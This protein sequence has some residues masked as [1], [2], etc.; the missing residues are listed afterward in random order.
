MLFSPG[1]CLICLCPF[2]PLYLLFGRN[3]GGKL[4]TE[5]LPPGMEGPP[6][7]PTGE[8]AA[9]VVLTTHWQLA[10][11]CLLGSWSRYAS[12]VDYSSENP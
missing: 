11:Y 6:G 7:P 10:V 4:V 9:P 2:P 12:H 5:T 8:A 3:L 1:V